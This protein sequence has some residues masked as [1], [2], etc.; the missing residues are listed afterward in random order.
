MCHVANVG[1][2]RAV[3]SGDAGRKVFSLSRDHKPLDEIE[4]K[5][6]IDN[7]GK[8]YQYESFFFIIINY[9]IYNRSQTP[10]LKSAEEGKPQQQT[11]IIL[12]PHRVFPGRLSVTRAFGDI[13]AKLPKLGGAPGVVVATP[14]V[15]SF[16]IID[17]HD[18]III[19]CNRKFR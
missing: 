5:R 8:I 19:A 18:F 3:M 2:S 4:Q 14:D 17:E 12:G 7:G 15:K 11:Q 9:F 1:D 6:I 10:I 13:E 16:K